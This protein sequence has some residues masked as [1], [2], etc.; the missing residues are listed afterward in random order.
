M[1]KQAL[2]YAVIFLVLV[3][4][5]YFLIFEIEKDKTEK[6]LAVQKSTEPQAALPQAGFENIPFAVTGSS[7]HT[8]VII[9][10]N[11][12]TRKFIINEVRIIYR[13]KSV[14]ILKIHDR[15]YSQI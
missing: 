8:E 7:Y 12:E 1:K 14:A 9:G 5:G 2:I 13:D 11:D 10:Y 4:A 3:T 15:I 6:S